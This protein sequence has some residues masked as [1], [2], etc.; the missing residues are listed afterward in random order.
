MGIAELIRHSASYLYLWKTQVFDIASAILIS[1]YG[2]HQK[3]E[4]HIPI[5][6]LQEDVYVLVEN[7]NKRNSQ[8]RINNYLT[9]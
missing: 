1:A 5:L 3:R 8:G 7:V 9:H 4:V 2:P 6:E